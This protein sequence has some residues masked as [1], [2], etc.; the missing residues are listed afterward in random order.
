[1][2]LLKS[3][4]EKSAVLIQCS[5]ECGSVVGPRK[6][7]VGHRR[8]GVARLKT[9]V[10]EKPEVVSA[11]I[12]GAALG[13][14]I[15]NAARRTAKLRR[16]RIGY[17]LE[18]LHGLLT[19]RRTRSVYRVVGIVRAVDLHQVGTATLATKIQTRS[20]RRA[21]RPAVIAANSRSDQRKR[22]IVALVDR[23]A[24]DPLLIDCRSYRG[25]GSLHDVRSGG[26]YHHPCPYFTPL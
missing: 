3:R 19:Y 22:K 6:W 13:Y 9:F 18:F 20:G 21:D 11:Q 8:E 10:T 14:N 16:K 15:H 4:K 23:K 24:F 2:S 25:P 17:H 5:D 12:V 26:R 7:R 1:M